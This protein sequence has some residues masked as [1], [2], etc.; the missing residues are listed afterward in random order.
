MCDI[1][2][3]VLSLQPVEDGRQFHSHQPGERHPTGSEKGVPK[4]HDS[5]RSHKQGAKDSLMSSI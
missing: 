4:S 3:Y 1:S 2:T 5:W